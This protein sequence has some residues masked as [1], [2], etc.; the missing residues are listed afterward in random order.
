MGESKGLAEALEQ[1]TLFLSKGGSSE[2]IVPRHE[3]VQKIDL[4]P[5]DIK[6]EGV[7]NYLS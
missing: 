5:T 2:A 1:L 3:V 7:T 4:S 6:L